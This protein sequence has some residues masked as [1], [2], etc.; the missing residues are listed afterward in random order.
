MSGLVLQDLVASR[1]SKRINIAI[2]DEVFDALDEIGVEKVIELLQELSDEKSTILVISHNE[3]LQ[4]YFTN[5]WTIVK[6][7]GF[8]TLE[9]SIEDIEEEEVA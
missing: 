2:F 9:H 3:H 6:K 5:S 1:S 4:S 7:D 8:S